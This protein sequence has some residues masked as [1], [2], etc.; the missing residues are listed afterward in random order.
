MNILVFFEY[1]RRVLWF[2]LAKVK[3]A[4]DHTSTIFF[5]FIV[6]YVGH[7]RHFFGVSV[8]INGICPASRLY[9][10]QTYFAFTREHTGLYS[11]TILTQHTTGAGYGL[12]VARA[13]SKDVATTVGQSDLQIVGKNPRFITIKDAIGVVGIAGK[14]G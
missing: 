1:Q 11:K 5:S 7:Q 4:C 2:E 14:G 6:V 3:V 10:S 8:S 12:W 13:G 9:L